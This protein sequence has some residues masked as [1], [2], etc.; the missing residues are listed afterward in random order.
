MCLVSSFVAMAR[1]R[2]A[3]CALRELEVLLKN[4]F[5][6]EIIYG[7]MFSGVDSGAQALQNLGNNFTHAFAIDSRAACRKVL[8]QNFNPDQVFADVKSVVWGEVHT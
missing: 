1:K 7:S 6:D 2:S 8:V 3:S 5:D 4:N